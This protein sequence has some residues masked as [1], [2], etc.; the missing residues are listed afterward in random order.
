MRNELPEIVRA[1]E[2][3]PLVIRTDFTDDAAWGEVFAALER[4]VEGERGWEAA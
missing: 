1:D 4:A 2:W 3:V